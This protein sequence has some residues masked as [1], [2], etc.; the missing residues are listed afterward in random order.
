V[1]SVSAA[2]T[3]SLRRSVNVLPVGVAMGL[4]VALMAGYHSGLVPSGGVNVGSAQLSW[5]LLIACLMLMVVGAL[6][7]YFVVP[8]NALLQHRGHVLMSAGR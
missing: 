1:G 5:F 7:G 6:A 3:V 4:I 8:M 2:A